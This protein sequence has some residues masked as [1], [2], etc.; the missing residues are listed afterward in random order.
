MFGLRMFLAE[1]LSGAKRQRNRHHC[2]MNR[3]H[4]LSL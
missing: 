4:G 3:F 1:G 2:R